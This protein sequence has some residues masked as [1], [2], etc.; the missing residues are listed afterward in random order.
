MM[1][2]FRIARNFVL[3]FTSFVLSL[4]AVM[5]LISALAAG[6]NR[7]ASGASA[8]RSGSARTAKKTM[9]SFGSEDELKNYFRQL[10]EERRREQ[11][12][13][14]KSE[15]QA[16]APGTA[17]QVATGL[18]KADGVAAKDESITNTQHAGVDEGASSNCTAIIS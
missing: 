4:A 3:S 13:R 9:R 1:N 5:G 10:A 12:V 18:A 8:L 2:N 16:P 6:G 15:A 7:S 17:N 11:T 14:A